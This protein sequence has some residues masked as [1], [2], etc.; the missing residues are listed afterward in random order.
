MSVVTVKL[1]TIITDEEGNEIDLGNLDKYEG[2]TLI[3]K[4]VQ[5]DKGKVMK[6]YKIKIDEEKI[7]MIKGV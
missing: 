7:N 5:A 4:I 2:Q 3:L 6:E 1:K